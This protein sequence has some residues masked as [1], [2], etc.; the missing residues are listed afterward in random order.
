[1]PADFGTPVANIDNK[2]GFVYIAC[3]LPNAVE[4]DI[5]R[6]AVV[7]FKG[8]SKGSC[9][10]EVQNASLN[11]ENGILITPHAITNGTLTVKP[12]AEQPTP[13]PAS[14]PSTGVGG[15]GPGSGGGYVPTTPTPT[16][17]Q[18]AVEG[19]AVTPAP[20]TP[21]PTITPPATAPTPASTPAPAP[22]L[23]PLFLILIV[24]AVIAGITIIVLRRK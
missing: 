11:D 24:T 20:A 2:E 22:G 19:V 5:A 16:E 14:A 6:L 3:A 10:L 13:T 7:R 12:S 17:K 23:T 1:L 18:T 15:G 8:L 4:K 21:A 9:L